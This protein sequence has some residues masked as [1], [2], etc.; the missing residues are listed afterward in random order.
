MLLRVALV[1]LMALGLTGFGTVAWIATRPPSQPSAA[2]PATVKLVTSARALHAGSLLKP[3]DLATAEIPA[4]DAR[5]AAFHDT[6]ETRSS[7]LGAMVRRSLIAG[8][9]I[10]AD[11]VLRPGDH[12]FLAAVLAP[13][14]RA[15]TV[16]V[17]AISGSAGL[18]WPGD[19]VDLILTQTIEDKA[20]PAAKRFAAETVLTNVRVIAIDQH[21]IEGASADTP[22]PKGARTVSLEVTPHQAEA[23]TVA[24]RLGHLSLVVRSADHTGEKPALPDPPT[25]ITWAG[26]VSPALKQSETGHGDPRTVRV[27]Q[28]SADG[29]EFHF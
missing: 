5:A 7:L 14:T 6:P 15:V 23:V 18:I 22:E 9:P 24:M 20:A 19:H 12:G 8:E 2:A 27:F 25:S 28:G 21:L 1:A 29:K 16:G 3:E 26:E 4:A 10:S 11:A 13:G 17:D